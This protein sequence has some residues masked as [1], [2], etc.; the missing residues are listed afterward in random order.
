MAFSEAQY[1][2]FIKVIVV[3]A[4]AKEFRKSAIMEKIYNKIKQ[5]NIIATGELLAF[6][7]SKAIIPT[8]DDRFLVDEGGIFIN[9]VK[10]GPNGT[11]VATSIRVKI[12]YGLTEGRYFY[13][14]TGSGDKRWY[15]NVDNIVNWIKIK[16]SRGNTFE[17]RRRGVKREAQKDWEIKSVAYAIAKG[18]SQKGIEKK[19]FLEPFEDKNYGVEASLR[20]ANNRIV[21]RLFELYGT[22]FTQIQNDVISNVL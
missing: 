9:T 7:A 20:R 22:T 8:R 1:K 12:R 15:P 5:G 2:N 14:T 18:M 11:P 19:D 21:E 13:L 16:K 6:R 17:I 4:V 10:I 3:A